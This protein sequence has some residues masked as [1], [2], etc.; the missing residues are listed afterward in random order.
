MAQLLAYRY[1]LKDTLS[2]LLR[3]YIQIR[4]E[5]EESILKG[6]NELVVV[7]DKN[8]RIISS[9]EAARG[10]FRLSEEKIISQ[11]LLAVFSLKGF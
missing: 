5:R 3:E 11:P 7:T 9:N 2:K 6:L 1:H 10:I 8:L 4:E